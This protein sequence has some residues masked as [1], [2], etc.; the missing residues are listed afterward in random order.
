M[1]IRNG[2]MLLSRFIF[3]VIHKLSFQL[4]YGKKFTK[5]YYK[6]EF[7]TYWFFKF[8]PWDILIY[9][10]FKFEGKLIATSHI[11]WGTNRMWLCCS[12]SNMIV[13]VDRLL[14]YCNYYHSSRVIFSGQPSTIGNIQSKKSENDCSNLQ[15]ITLLYFFFEISKF[16]IAWSH[17]NRCLSLSIPKDCHYKVTRDAGAD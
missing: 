4:R 11:I 6:V 12:L 2:N 14:K 13:T 15:K 5:F 1:N 17:I 7:I 3:I 16:S 9:Y 10:F 8:V